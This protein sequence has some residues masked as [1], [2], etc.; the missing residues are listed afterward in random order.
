MTR[1]RIL[2]G[3]LW[4][5]WAGFWTQIAHETFGWPAWI[6][7][8]MLLALPFVYN[9]VTNWWMA[10]S[11]WLSFV[12][13]TSAGACGMWLWAVV[14]PG[15]QYGSSPYLV[16][17]WI[18]VGLFWGY[19]AVAIGKTYMT[20][21]AHYHPENFAALLLLCLNKGFDWQ[22]WTLLHPS[23]VCGDRPMPKTIDKAPTRPGVRW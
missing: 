11:G 13:F 18:V 3:L 19:I 14:S 4:I 17:D 10:T 5:A 2:Y 22:W 16:S 23:E 20:I 1:G 9:R 15:M 8:I 12:V 6:S 21:E 7:I